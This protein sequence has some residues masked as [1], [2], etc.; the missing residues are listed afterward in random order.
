MRNQLQENNRLRKE[1]GILYDRFKKVATQNESLQMSIDSLEMEASQLRS[2]VQ[3]HRAGKKRFESDVQHLQRAVRQLDK[4]ERDL[5]G[6]LLDLKEKND[7]LEDLNEWNRLELDGLQ[8]KYDDVVRE[9]EQLLK[10]VETSKK[11]AQRNQDLNALILDLR[12]DKIETESSLE[13]AK[14]DI[15]KLKSRCLE[16]EGQKTEAET[17]CEDIYGKKINL[18]LELTRSKKD[19]L[20]W[21]GKNVEMAKELAFLKSQM[22]EFRD[23]VL[24]GLESPSSSHLK[25]VEVTKTV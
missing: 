24:V 12:E 25:A 2:Q 11:L 5:D 15:E 20:L 21:N 19:A 13:K 9:N 1:F 7:A 8:R 16:L 4:R 18:Q 6:T 3:I 10:S 14:E 23:A 22:D 17:I